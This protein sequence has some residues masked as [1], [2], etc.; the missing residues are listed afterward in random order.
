MPNRRTVLNPSS[1]GELCDSVTF[2]RINN[3]V[4]SMNR[5][6]VEGLPLKYIII[7]II[8]A[9]VLGI[10]MN[11]TSIISEGVT[12]AAIIFNN[13]LANALANLTG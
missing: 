13:T 5:R 4:F 8:A 11:V 9:L 7:A 2:I 10:V 12:G 1:K 6:G 3:A